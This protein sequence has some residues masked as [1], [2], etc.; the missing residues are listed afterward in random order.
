MNKAVPSGEP[1]DTHLST[2]V[3]SEQDRKPLA[4]D[5]GNRREG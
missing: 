4:G 5:R 3:T 2:L 1:R